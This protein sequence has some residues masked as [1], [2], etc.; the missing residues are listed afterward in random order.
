MSFRKYGGLNHNATNNVV[1][2]NYAT[3]NALNVTGQIGDTNTDVVFKSDIK[4]V[5]ATGPTGIGIWFADGTFQYTAGGGGGGGT[6]PTGPASG[7]TGNTGPKGDMGYTGPKG[8][9]GDT[10]PKGDIGNTGD[11]GPTGYTGP[12][13]DIGPSGGLT[14]LS[15]PFGSY[16]YHDNSTWEVG[17]DEIKL[18]TNAGLTGQQGHAIAIGSKGIVGLPFYHGAGEFNQEQFAIAIGTGAGSSNQGIASIAI[19]AKA[20]TTNQS[21][22]AIAIGNE[23]GTFNQGTTAIAIGDQAGRDYQGTYA[24]AIGAFSGRDYQGTHAIGI[25]YCAGYQNQSEDAIAIG[26]K[27]GSTYQSKYAIAIGQNAGRDFQGECAIAIGQNAGIGVQPPI[28]TYIAQYG[29]AIAIGCNAGKNGQGTNS[30][31]IGCNAGIGSVNYYRN[32]I[33]L[34][35][36]GNNLQSQHNDSCYIS[37]IRLSSESG[38]IL[39]YDDGTKEVFANVT[40]TFV[41]DHPTESDKYLVHACL[42]G[43]ESGVYYRGRGEITNGSSTVIQLPNY[44][45]TL[46]CDLTV[47]LTPIFKSNVY[48]NLQSSEVS[49]NQFTVHGNNCEFFWLVQGKREDIETQPLKSVTEVKGSGPYKWI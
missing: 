14:G 12:K 30:I 44:V 2:S 17:N 34:N 22:D 42:E 41:I 31:A 6:G 21:S 16:I 28:G 19:G 18:G 8:D 25:G 46:A 27:A 5:G 26:F 20:G 33:I 37:P 47:Q 29:C 35:A 1:R 48:P 36:S 49:N 23:A 3:N 4:L 32:T 13:G 10:G 39:M 15:G 24:L 40:K 45:N 43:P 7:P 11:T 9:K 38:K